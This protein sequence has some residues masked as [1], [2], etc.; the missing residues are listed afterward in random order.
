MPPKSDAVRPETEPE[1]LAAGGVYAPPRTVTD[2]AECDFYHTM[3]IPGY[4]LV[5]G[6][7]D[8]RAGA[9]EYLGNVDFRGKRVLEI[10]TGSGF[11]C[12]HME[13]RGADVVA[14]DLSEEHD[15]DLVPFAGSSSAEYE[16]MR[17]EHIRKLNNAWWLTHRAYDSSAKAVYGTVYEVPEAIGDV[18]VAT[19]CAVLRHLRDPFLALE[20]VLR[21]TRRTVVVTASLSLRYSVPQT[22]VG[23]L[24]P[25]MLF[26]PEFRTGEPKE[27]WW[28]LTP[29]V[30]KKMIGVLGFEKT[31]VTYHRQRYRGG[32]RLFYT[33]VGHRT[34]E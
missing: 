25:G 17:R 13:Q 23:R 6:Q 11:L 14:Y 34:R 12:F 4:G 18:D 20:R 28:H 27:S 16:S 30:V 9:D 24:R 2:L 21:L 22:M 26:L 19:F 8:L 31:K 3:E 5:E 32:R 1:D 33:V 29:D 15:W 10:G 7:W